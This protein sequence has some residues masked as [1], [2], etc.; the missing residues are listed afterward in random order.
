MKKAIKGDIIFTK[1]INQFEIIEDG[2]LVIKDDKIERACK[3]LDE[4][5]D[6]IDYTNHIII[7]GFVDVHMHAP[8][9][10]NIGL[11]ADRQLL[12]WLNTYTFKEESKYSNVDFAKKS[13]NRFVDKLCKNGITS[14]VIFG[15]IYKDTTIHL[16]DLI[17]EVGLRAYV[18]KVNMDRNS[19][20]YYIE[21]TQKS[22]EDTVEFVEKTINKYK[23]VKPII[24][25]R[26][27]P[28]CTVNL[29]RELGDIAEKYDL[30]VQ[31]HLSENLDE[32]SLVKELHQECTSY[33]NV[34]ERYGLTRK[35]KT[36]MAHCV[37][38]DDEEIK[39]LI[40]NEIIVA[41]SPYSNGNISSGIAPVKKMLQKGV[42]VGLASDISG[43]HDMF[44][45]RIMMLA[46]IFSKM[47]WVHIDN[48]YTNLTDEELFYMATKGGGE[49]FGKVGSFEEG[50]SADFLVIDDK[51][52]EDSN[53]RNVRQ[54][55]QRFLYIGDDRNI[56]SV[57]VNGKLIKKDKTL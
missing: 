45:G 38:A 5:I 42:K 55:L 7:P 32:I 4:N 21:E 39:S 47:R 53:E 50:Y 24:T 15:S 3:E 18:G 30:K 17:E 31:S 19:P 36:V 27:V 49:F 8:Q 11:G 56:K 54:R 28:S 22:I 10:N 51:S 37:W 48:E 52:L 41:H 57:Y 43:G 16:M 2:Y 9:I 33:I 1:N 20:S 29:M 46:S 13:Y 40:Q 23:N 6:I 34:Y 25:P 35:N 44:M 26:F 12:D 14:S